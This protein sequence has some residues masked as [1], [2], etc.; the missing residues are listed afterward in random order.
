MP[1]SLRKIL[2]I[3]TLALPTGLS[4]CHRIAFPSYPA[5]YREFAY[6][7]SGASNTVAVLDLV[8]LRQDRVLQVGANPTGIAANPVRNE[9]YAVNAGSAKI[10]TGL[11]DAPPASPAKSTG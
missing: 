2:A 4:G 5:A 6:V 10:F 11:V 9:I 3:S 8:Y 7:T 1:A